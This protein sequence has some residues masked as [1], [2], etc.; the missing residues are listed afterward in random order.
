MS[1]AS[2]G[3]PVAPTRRRSRSGGGTASGPRRQP[4]R[5]SAERRV[6]GR[7]QDRAVT[8]RASGSRPAWPGASR[9]PRRASPTRGR[10]RRWAPA[11]C[12]AWPSGWPSCRSTRSTSCPGRTTC[13]S[14]AGSGPIRARRSTARRDRRRA[15]FEYWAHE[16]SF[17][18]VRLH[19]LPALAHGARP[20]SRRG[21]SMT[22]LA[23]GAARVRRRG[24]RAGARPR[25]APRRRARRGPSPTGP[26]ACGTGTPARRRWSTSSSPAW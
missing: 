17:L 16:A 14:S 5:A 2:S 10:R 19:P 11:S 24:A 26:G 1:A 7:G 18:P 4:R 25:P 13:R 8:I 20:R 12:G 6:G 23:A 3:R 15:V 9:W 22:R 21:A